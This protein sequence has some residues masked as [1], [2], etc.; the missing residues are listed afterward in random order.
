MKKTIILEDR[1]DLLKIMSTPHITVH[2]VLPFDKKVVV[3]YSEPEEEGRNV[4]VMIAAW[5]TAHSRIMLYRLL[6]IL[7]E[8]TCYFDTGK[9]KIYLILQMF[10]YL[11]I[12]SYLQIALFLLRILTNQY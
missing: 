10:I 6:S 7:G 1:T 4:N 9:F 2:S 5:T 12:F 3:T 11:I 8:R